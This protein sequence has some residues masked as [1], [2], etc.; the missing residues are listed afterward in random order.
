MWCLPQSGSA[1]APESVCHLP[2]PQLG[3]PGREVPGHWRGQEDTPHAPPISSPLWASDFS[4]PALLCVLHS[5]STG[6]VTGQTT[7]RPQ[8]RQTSSW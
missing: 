5:P 3:A 4:S 6:P 2:G 8:A 7:P 1:V